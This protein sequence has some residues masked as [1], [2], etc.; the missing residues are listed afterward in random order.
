MQISKSY[1]LC[2]YTS[3]S[4]SI[5]GL[6]IHG[7]LEILQQHPKEAVTFFNERSFPSADEVEAFYIPV[8]SKNEEE[9]A[10][11]E[12]VIYNWG[13]CLKNIESKLLNV[14]S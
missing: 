1:D 7:L 5:A 2:E 6:K 14:M 12:L 8:F 11:E 10:E 13:K 3:I 4:L 9:K